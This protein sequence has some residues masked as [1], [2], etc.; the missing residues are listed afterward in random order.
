MLIGRH[1]FIR[2]S[3]L[4][5]VAGRIDYIS[6]P[7]R[8]EY[9]YATYQT[10]G[11]TPEFWK[12][13]ARENQLDFKASGSAGKCIEGREFIIALPESF[14]QYRAGD[15]VRLF[16]ETFHKRYGVEC[17]A[18]LH[19]NKTKT[20]YHIHLVFSE[21]KMLEQ[22]EVKI[23]TRNMFYDE[24]GKHRRQKKEI[25]DEQGN[26]RAGCSIIPK[27]EV[28]ES[29]IFTKKDEWFKSDVF[30][31]EVKEMFM[32]IINSHVKEESEK[33]SVFQQGGV[34]L[35]TKKIGK[36]NPKEAEIR[37][38]NAVR[39]EWNRTVD[40]ALVE[41]VPEED[42]LTVKR[43]KITDK[44]LQS[45][46]THGWLPDMFQQII[47]GAKDFLQEMI[48]KFKLP[49]KPVPKIDLQEWNDMR[50]LMEKLQKQSQAMKSTQQ[51]IS[52]LKKQLSETTGFFKGKARKSLEGKIEQAEKQ[53]KRIRTDMEQTVKQ[54][55]YPDV[56]CFAKTYQK[57]EKLVREY[58]E[59]MRVWEKQTTAK[60][61]SKEEI[62][63]QRTIRKVEQKMKK[64]IFEEMGGTYV[65]CGDYLIP[66]LTLP[67]EE[68]PRFVGVW[69]Q[70]HLQYLKEYRRNVYLDLMMSG[71]LNSYLADIEEQAQE[72][73]ERIVEQMKQAQ[74]IT[75]Q[76]KADNAWEW[77]GRMNNIQACAREIVDK[78]IIYQ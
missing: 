57:S 63:G 18:A 43:E 77:V 25:L 44:T 53:E 21:R 6:N 2:Q 66:N 40:V 75:E 51:E 59:E 54:A 29:H 28:Y 37:A 32:E 20:N 46:R 69:G 78:E 8:Q 38:D 42:I 48:F 39:Q 27:G 9:L 58:N 10:E 65:R 60:T 73:F 68:E 62:N 71:R 33:L 14:V 36:N 11:A 76:L 23:A 56:Q 35:A 24:Q 12:N 30:T 7:K 55:G 34:Y 1:S 22:P 64:T 26:L 19:H 17:S 3:K 70:R 13:L 72:R 5:D 50:K 4:F 49:P 47:R 74:G 41:G 15:V 67:E 16:T 45:I 61:D 31:R 52:S